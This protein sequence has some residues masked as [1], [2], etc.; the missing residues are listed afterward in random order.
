MK[1]K[2]IEK[3]LL[4]NPANTMPHDSVRRLES[5]IQSIPEETRGQG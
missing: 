5:E 2:K 3:V 1:F 4:V